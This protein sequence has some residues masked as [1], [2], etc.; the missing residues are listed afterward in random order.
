MQKKVVYFLVIMLLTMSISC[1]AER[2]YQIKRIASIGYWPTA[3]FQA[4]DVNGDNIPEIIYH[5]D[6]FLNL[7][8]NSLIN[9]PVEILDQIDSGSSTSVEIADL[10]GNGINEIIV[11]QDSFPAYFGTPYLYVIEFNGKEYKKI[12][13][14]SEI[15][16]IIKMWPLNENGKLKF[17]VYVYRDE[18]PKN[19]ENI[20]YILEYTDD[21]KMKGPII[22]SGPIVYVGKIN[23]ENENGIVVL[24][25]EVSSIDL[26]RYEATDYR[27]S[28]LF[29]YIIPKVFKLEGDN[30]V[31]SSEKVPLLETQIWGWLTLDLNN[32][33]KLEY[34]IGT[35]D[36]LKPCFKIFEGDKLVYKSDVLTTKHQKWRLD[37]AVG[38]IEGDGKREVV[39]TFGYKL[40]Y[41]DDGYQLSEDFKDIFDTY[42]A[43]FQIELADV[44][45]DG[46]DEILFLAG[47]QDE[48][49]FLMDYQSYLY[50]LDIE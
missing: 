37:L 15:G 45:N 12:W 49:E 29:N 25:K 16:D 34:I 32:D 11:G 24:T 44:D 46:K 3:F 22:L 33:G 8:V 5:L 10:N 27:G 2:N 31:E 47:S 35:F 28:R 42:P 41:T 30:L 14:S 18:K 40:S 38:D 13:R 43:I 7:K 48:Y 20:M 36:N 23:D 21:F 50:M 4:G 17:I 9:E 39:M 6:N 19:I 26:I 1:I